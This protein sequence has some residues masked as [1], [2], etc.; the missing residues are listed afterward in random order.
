MSNY[1]PNSI[2][3]ALSKTNFG[4]VKLTDMLP[5]LKIAALQ[6]GLKLNRPHD[7]CIAIRI[8]NNSVK[9]N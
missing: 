3:Y 1:N 5:A 7:L 4:K 9:N 6:F 8:C 2:V